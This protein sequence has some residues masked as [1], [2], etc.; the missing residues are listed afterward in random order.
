MMAPS[1]C[2]CCRTMCLSRCKNRP[3]LPP[4]VHSRR[5]S[6]AFLSERKVLELQLSRPRS[7]LGSASGKSALVPSN[8]FGNT[9]GGLCRLAGHFSS[10]HVQGVERKKGDP[11]TSI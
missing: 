1:S 7:T 10:V 9:G 11:I 4:R 8:I 3:T 5:T 6:F 2:G